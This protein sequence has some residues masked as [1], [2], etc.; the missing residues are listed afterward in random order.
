MSLIDEIKLKHF[1][2]NRDGKL[3]KREAR[4]S[5]DT[6]AKVKR[7]IAEGRRVGNV[8]RELV[9]DVFLADLLQH[10]AE[11]Q[12]LTRSVSSGLRRQLFS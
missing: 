2:Q 7:S 12:K 5:K 9:E 4:L 3:S 11:R 6:I 10:N 1:D 8:R